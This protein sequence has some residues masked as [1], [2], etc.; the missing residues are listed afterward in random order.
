M[1]IVDKSNGYVYGKEYFIFACIWVFQCFKRNAKECG[2]ARAK[3]KTSKNKCKIM[4]NANRKVCS[5]KKF[6]KK[7]SL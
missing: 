5:L 3:N 2:Y 6:I 1:K 4:W 7:V